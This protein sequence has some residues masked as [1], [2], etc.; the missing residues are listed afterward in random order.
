MKIAQGILTA[1]GGAS[2]HA[3]P[4]AARWARRASSVAAI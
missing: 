1:F 3:L 4:S 2:P